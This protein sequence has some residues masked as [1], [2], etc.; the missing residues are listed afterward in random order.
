MPDLT[1]T[2]LGTGTSQGVPMIGCD[3]RVCRSDDVRDARMRS[4]VYIQTPEAAW[5]IDTGPDFRAQ[6]LRHGV[7]ELD[8]VVYTHAHT[9]H[10]MGFDDLRP[11]CPPGRE[12]PIYAS[13]D[14][15][16]HLRRVFEFAFNGQNRFPGYIHPVPHEVEEAFF[17]GKTELTPLPVP[18][19]R[20]TVNGYLLRRA[21]EPLVAYL[22]DC[23][24]V[25][26]TV[27]DQIVGVR[28]LIIDALRR[29]PHPTHLSID[30]ALA[31]AARVQ[32]AHTW[33]THLCH[34][35]LHAELEAELPAGVRVAFDGLKLTI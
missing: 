18:H 28:H 21:G 27:V 17:L 29:K 35:S 14:T 22:S 19:G 12:I 32:P 7:R 30:E 26:D 24:A 15:M 10:I 1:L 33:F 25:P 34:D 11:F 16:G 23:K 13:G 20:A 4:S 31:V 2:F 9:D 3:C 5:V 6:C 8:A